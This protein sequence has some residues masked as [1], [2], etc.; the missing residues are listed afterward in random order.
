VRYG[1]ALI[2]VAIA[3]CWNYLLPPVY[4]E[5]HYSFFSVA[6]LAGA[7]FG[8]LGP[9][10]LATGISSLTSAYLF[11]AP[12]HSFRIEAPEA[13]ERLAMFV[14]EG[15]IISSVGH[16][17]RNNRM[18]ELASALSRYSAALVLV[19]SAAVWKLIFLPALERRV[20][21]TY[22]YSAIVATSW[23]AGAGPGLVATALSAASVHYL[24]A[25]S[26]GVVAPGDPAV[27]LFA[28]EATALCL[29][30]SGC[31]REASRMISTIS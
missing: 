14:V 12:F 5:S 4:G 22:F 13:A 21:F 17:I 1:A 20:P 7:L 11:I 8:G 30:P 9:G 24:F 19:A 16:V 27:L 6:I 3:A 29:R 31:S 18:P 28:L 15:A 10:L 23:V 2:L 25:G 26:T